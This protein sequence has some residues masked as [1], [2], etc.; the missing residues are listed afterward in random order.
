MKEEN[1]ILASIIIPCRNE[2]KHI[3]STLNALLNSTIKNIEILVVDGLSNDGTREKLEQLKNQ[4]HNIKIIDNH[5]QVTPVA[6]NLGIKNSTGTFIFIVGARHTLDPNYI[7]TC[8]DI[9]EK[10]SKIGC[11]GGKVINAYENRE[12]LLISKALSSSF[13]VGGGN[14]RIKESDSFVDTVGTPAYRRTIFDEIGY[15]DE[16]LLR[17]QDDEFNFRVIKQGY[18]ILF[19]TKTSIQ[20]YVRAN[21]KNLYKQYFQYGYWK[22]YV[23]KKHR[24]VTTLRQ[25]VPLF[26]VLYLFLGLLSSFIYLPLIKF[27]SLGIFIYLFASFYSANKLSENLDETFSIMKAFFILHFGY[28]YGYLRGIIDFFILNKAIKKDEALTR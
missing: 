18:K 7:E 15:F 27:N 19:T 24:T 26:F 16:E 28:G 4:F 10:D 1:N 2:V 25:V 13:A 6:F 12:S 5:L 17:N 8:I 22:V 9:L 21:F 11:V 14:F 3:E 23:N 20:Y